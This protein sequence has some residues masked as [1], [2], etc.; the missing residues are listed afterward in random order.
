M[1][2]ADYFFRNA[3]AASQVLAGY[4]ESRLA[5]RL[6]SVRLG[7]RVGG[8]AATAEGRA[9]V[10]L[11][12]RLAARLYPMMSLTADGDE[13]LAR[14]LRRSAA[15]INPSIEWVDDANYEIVIGSP[16]NLR[17]D[18]IRVFVGSSEWTAL[19]SPSGPRAIGSTQNPFGAG[20]AAAVAVA[21]IFRAV[22]LDVP[23]LD[24][25]SS[26]DLA[27]PSPL[28]SIEPN[29]NGFEAVL[30]GAGAIGNAAAWALARIP[31][32][33]VVHIVDHQ[34]VDLG[35]CQRYVLCDRSD[36]GAPKTEVAAR[37]FRG[38]VLARGHQLTAQTFLARQGYSWS[39]ALL[40]LDSARDRVAVQTSLP[41]WISNAWTQP[42]DLGVAS[43]DF[44]EGACVGCVY[45]P[46]KALE[47]EDAILANA[48]GV[49]NRVRQIRTLLHTG[50]GASLD[51]LKAISEAKAIP[52][53]RLLPFE[54]KH[55]RTLY[56]EGFCG[57]A[58]IPLS[59]VG[60]PRS[61]AHV[62][63]AHQ[64][65]LAGVLLAAAFVRRL[66]GIEPRG[67]RATKVDVLS[68]YGTIHTQTIAKDARGICICQDSD[69]R[70]VYDA[71]HR[72][73]K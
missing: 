1:A 3:I 2:L 44:L 40:A 63:L 15:R 65:A 20:V 7:I 68:S 9:L 4:D 35:N 56:V 28:H 43:H 10:D 54:G 52:V 6:N 26:I 33:G 47:N 69:Y 12:V 66:L 30:F 48:F 50:E 53:E 64:S 49:P 42:G 5:E 31:G 45:L 67:T 62:P 13:T 60:R 11:T 14:D 18:A 41:Q 57:G 61:D 72:R 34:A 24:G 38:S 23:Q 55:V 21:N 16:R 25:E 37:V 71:K 27:L 39:H 73:T 32:E 22:F 17:G 29:S 59:E 51:L 46:E 36:E 70:N 19:I 58:V 8:D